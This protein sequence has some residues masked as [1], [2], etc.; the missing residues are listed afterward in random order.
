[1]RTSQLVCLERS[2]IDTKT[3][4]ATTIQTTE[5]GTRRFHITS[6]NITI[7]SQSGSITGVA[8]IS[9]GTVGPAY[10]DLQTAGALTGL[11]AQ[12]KL[13]NV[14][15]TTGAVRSTIAPNTAV[16]INISVGAVGAGATQTL[17]VRVF[18]FYE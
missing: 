9:V 4:A 2:G 16:V 14:A 8:T 6:I 12:D 11:T 15:I 1:M 13:L 7:D 18:G 10:T 3:V 17:A 5:N